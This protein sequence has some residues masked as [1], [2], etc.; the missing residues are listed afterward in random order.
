MAASVF[1]RA[2]QPETVNILRAQ[3]SRPFNETPP[4]T[5]PCPSSRN[6]DSVR[7]GTI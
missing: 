6:A 4:I 2:K 5:T 1:G 3:V 7:L